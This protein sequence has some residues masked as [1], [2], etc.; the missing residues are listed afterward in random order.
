MQKSIKT[1][2]TIRVITVPP[3]LICALLL[4]MFFK[5]GNDFT[6]PIE[7]VLALFFQVVM[8][9]MA[10]PLQKVIPAYKDKG[11]DGQRNLAFILNGLG[12]TFAVIYGLIFNISSVLRF[13]F[14]VY[15]ASV[16]ILTIINKVIKLRASGHACSIVG[17]MICFVYF[18]G[19][20]AVLLCA[21]LIA[22]I[23]WASLKL[24]RHTIKEF[25]IGSAVSATAFVSCILIFKL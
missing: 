11:R 13:I 19:L 10:Y 5:S 4:T 17:T 6:K 7:L 16:L 21:V 23:L 2:K 9:I 3:V 15:F 1:A 24:K 8:P 12:Y 14:F 18:V 22:L 20:K 25:M